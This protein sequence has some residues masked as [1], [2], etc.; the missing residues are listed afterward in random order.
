M[1]ILYTLKMPARHVRKYLSF[2]RIRFVNSLQYRLAALSGAATQFFW[3]FMLIAMYRAF[4][5]AGSDAGT[6]TPALPM[7]MEAGNSAAIR[8]LSMARGC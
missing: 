7:T 1:H 2:F 5:E 8:C 6:V 4:Y 3:G